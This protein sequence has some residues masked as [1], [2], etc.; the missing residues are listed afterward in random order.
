MAV[1]VGTWPFSLE[2]VKL[3]SRKLREGNGCI[4][5]LESGINLI[6]DD[7]DTGLYFVGRGGL[8]NSKGILECDAAVMDGE[9][10]R[11]GA[12]AA[13]QGVATAFSVARCVM[14]KSPH[15]ML[16]GSGAQEFAQSNGFPVESNSALQTQQSREAFQKFLEKSGEEEG[17]HDTIGILVMDSRSHLV[18]GVSSSGI[19][20]K[21]PGRVGDSPLPGSGLYADNEIGAAAA[22][23]DGDKMMRF[24]P[25]FHVVQ[26]MRQA[27]R[28]GHSPQ[29]S[30]ELVIKEAQQKARTATKPFEM[31]LIAINKKGDFGAAG[32][33]T[34][35][36]DERHNTLYTG[37]PFVVWTEEMGEPEI[38]VRPPLCF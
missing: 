3:I 38:R 7:P 37:F 1:V 18:A 32:T 30:C 33:V 10:C 25:A 35:C 36:K 23:G 34:S 22:T 26:L 5:A 11:F 9:T 31:A 24:C 27:S 4:D 29:E 8:P 2:A 28:F 6:E 16:V 14:E 17:G 13:L 21:H 20:F 12:V 19:A 15:S